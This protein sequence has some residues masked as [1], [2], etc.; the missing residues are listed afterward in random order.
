MT[1]SLKQEDLVGR[2]RYDEEL[3][4]LVVTLWYLPKESTPDEAQ[5]LKDEFLRQVCKFLLSQGKLFDIKNTI[6]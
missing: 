5:S 2:H 4:D 6:L 3:P 1:P